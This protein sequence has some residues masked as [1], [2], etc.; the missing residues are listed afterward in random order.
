MPLVEQGRQTHGK[1]GRE[2]EYMLG[3]PK[4]DISKAV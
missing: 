2:E 3:I 4:H 1:G